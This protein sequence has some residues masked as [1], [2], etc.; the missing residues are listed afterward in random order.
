MP[1][2]V[3]RLKYVRNIAPSLSDRRSR[4]DQARDL[5]FGV[6]TRGTVLS[7][8]AKFGK[9]AVDGFRGVTAVVGSPYAKVG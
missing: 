3:K 4:L 5:R 1:K 6:Y 7:D 8:R 2:S 9:R